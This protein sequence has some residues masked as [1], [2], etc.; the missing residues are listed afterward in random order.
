MAKEQHK[1]DALLYAGVTTDR[2]LN[3][4]VRKSD[5]RIE[6]DF[7][8]RVKWI[9][10]VFCQTMWKYILKGVGLEELH[11]KNGLIPPK[12]LN[13]IMKRLNELR[14]TLPQIKFTD[15]DFREIT[16]LKHL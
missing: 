11:E 12:D 5:L 4:M 13:E 3:L 1:E 10:D 15:K 14:S 8:Y 16:G 6:G 7:N 9:H 2:A